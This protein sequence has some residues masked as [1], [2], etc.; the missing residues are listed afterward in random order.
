MYFYEDIPKEERER[1][2]DKL[3]KIVV[4]YNLSVPGI[5]FFDST[6]YLNRIGSQ[7]LVFSS[8]VLNSII[9]SWEADK[10]AAIFE[11]RESV[12]YLLDR[13]E[14]LEDKKRRRVEEL[15]DMQKDSDKKGFFKK[16]LSK[17][18]KEK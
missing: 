18:R 5:I 2:L 3:A 15:K 16:I 7:F 11:K 1:M 17:F 13:I 9:P 14:E 12:E 6:K 4:K 8:P 10:Y